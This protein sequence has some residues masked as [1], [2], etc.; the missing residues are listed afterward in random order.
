MKKKSEEFLKLQEDWYARIRRDGFE[1]IEDTKSGNEYLKRWDSSYFQSRYC[2][3]IFKGK[4]SYYQSAGQ[5]FYLNLFKNTKEKKIWFFH[6]EGL[7]M[8]EIASKMK[9]KLSVVHQTIAFYRK[10]MFHVWSDPS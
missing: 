9:I 3:Q 7:S 10:I 4:E 6:S 2:P 1:D 8:R 5:F